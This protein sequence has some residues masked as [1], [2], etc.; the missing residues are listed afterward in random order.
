MKLPGCR[1][2]GLAC[3]LALAAPCE[4]IVFLD[5]SDPTH[6]TT[7]PGD[8]S[9]WQYEGEFGYFLG[10]P[11][12]PYYFITAKHFGGA[13]G[14]PLNF[15]GDP[16]TTIGF[17]DVAGTDL[18]VWEVQH[19]KPFPT[20]APVSSGASDIGAAASVFGRGAQRGDA[21]L[22]SG[23]LK[24]W[25]PGTSN[26]LKRWGKNVV[27]LAIPNTALGDFLQCDFD[28]PGM[29]DECHLSVGDSGGG[30]FVLENGLWRL[31]GVNYAVDG[32]FRVPPAGTP[33]NAAL[34]D[35]G[36]LEYQDETSWIAV[37]DGDQNIGSSFY[38]SRISSSLAW[39]TIH[40]GPEV[41][42]LAPESFA[43]WE[44]LYFTPAEMGNPMISGNLADPDGD[45]ISNL[46]EFSLNLDPTFNELAIMTSGTGLRGLPVARLE[47]NGSERLTI[48]FARR[49]IG[50]GAALVY[51][52][53]FSSDLS[54]WQAVGTEAVTG[55][56][57][58][59]E[60]VKITDSI[61]TNESTKRFVRLRVVRSE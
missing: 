4:A 33:F 36:G 10:V 18:R 8:N 53:E 17:Q 45:G 1:A 39:L 16:Y 21:F 52:P 11:I 12:A 5:T 54:D 43:A 27:S 42:S 40:V 25:V 47:T 3:V 26:Y 37:P 30:L 60:R 48:E 55:I 49:T 50:S 15:H 14:E 28:N 32:P 58:R 6:N 24:G 59:W 51:I 34:F 46:L 29:N 9:G 38:C 13:V 31:A 35:C 23:V 57:S 2:I 20:Y 22:L 19:T 56:N 44:K 41:N 7:T 61:T